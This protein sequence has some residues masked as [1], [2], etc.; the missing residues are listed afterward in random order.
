MA[1]ALPSSAAL[2]RPGCRKSKR[3]NRS[4]ARFSTGVPVSAILA[5]ARTDFV[6]RACFAPGFSIACASSRTMRRQSAR[7]A[8]AGG[9]HGAA[10]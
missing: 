8:D 2:A 6:A 7:E 3:L 9:R 10:R 1:D 4:P 5:R